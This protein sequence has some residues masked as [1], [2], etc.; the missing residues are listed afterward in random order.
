MRYA[1][2]T[3]VSGRKGRRLPGGAPV[4]PAVSRRVPHKKGFRRKSRLVAE[5]PGLS[6][7]IPRTPPPTAAH[8]PHAT[9]ECCVNPARA[10]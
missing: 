9:R 7:E 8:V 5:N 4:H 1:G 6:R 2:A 3:V 10:P